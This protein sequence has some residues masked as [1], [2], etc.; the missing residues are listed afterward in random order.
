MHARLAMTNPRSAPESRSR[1]KLSFLILFLYLVVIRVFGLSASKIAV[2]IG[3]TPIF[4]TDATLALLLVAMVREFPGRVLWWLSSAMGAR[5]IGV[6]VWILVVSAAVYCAAAFEEF[7][8]LAL[9]D[10]AI[11]SYALFFPLTYFALGT[12]DEAAKLV[13]VFAYSGAL[14]ALL[15]LV[16]AFTGLGIGIDSGERFLFGQS[17]SRYASGDEAAV[18][19]GSF[20][21]LLGYLMFDP[22]QRGI[23]FLLLAI[24]AAAIAISTVRSGVVGALLAVGL[25]LVVGNSRQ[26]LLLC[27]V[28]ALLGIALLL[29]AAIPSYELPPFL[30]SFY[31]SLGS[32]SGGAADPTA[33]FRILRWKYVFDLWAS[34]PILGI[35]YGVQLLPASLD[36]ENFHL[37]F[38][39]GGMPH[40]TFLF[41]LARMGLFGFAL[42]GFC[43]L[44]GLWSIARCAAIGRGADDL[45]AANL[46]LTM[47]AYG[48]LNLFFERPAHNAP[49]WIALAIAVRL[50]ESSRAASLATPAAV[51]PRPREWA[52]PS[53]QA[54]AF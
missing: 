53:A 34:H 38:F 36:P 24:C 19:T 54:Q 21:A 7:R 30:Q 22:K 50:S 3:P 46:L 20:G 10:L 48:A 5:A 28:S 6:A 37:G 31:L 11:F 27:A 13:R 41:V 2:N 33:A 25:A 18:I 23:H 26:R 43:W 8:A 51:A 9:R 1:L 17:V 35:G 44:A 12:R 47:I 32:A 40:N 29:G 14:V 39:N 42:I 52:A 45:A 49:F 4:L 16:N 15:I